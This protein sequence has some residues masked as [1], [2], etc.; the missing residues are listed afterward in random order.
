MVRA[1]LRRAEQRH[2]LDKEL[3]SVLDV[4]PSAISKLRH[5][6]RAQN[7]SWRFLFRWAEVVELRAV[8]I[9]ADNSVIVLG[10]DIGRDLAALRVGKGMSQAALAARVVTVSQNIGRR[11][12]ASSLM[13]RVVETHLRGLDARLGL[14]DATGDTRGPSLERGAPA[15][16]RA[17][18]SATLSASAVE[19]GLNVRGNSVDSAGDADAASDPDPQE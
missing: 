7:P 1:L 5:T 3:A 12:K 9:R 14:W 10:R 17:S 8:A 6:V 19:A 16:L 4:N 15:D 13:L 11:E 2:F 18:A